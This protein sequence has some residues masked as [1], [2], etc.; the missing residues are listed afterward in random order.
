MSN[1]MIE[2][3][4]G[5]N[6][7][8]LA[9]NGQNIYV[10][11]G[12]DAD[13]I[14]GYDDKKSK[15]TGSYFNIDAGNGNNVVT[16]GSSWNHAS[17]QCGKDA[18]FVINKANNSNIVAGASNDVI[19][20]EGNYT[21]I[22]GGA[23]G[24]IITNYGSHVYISGDT[25][26]DSVRPSSDY[27]YTSK[28]TDVTIDGGKNDDIIEAWHDVRAS[29]SGG[30]GND[31]IYLYRVTTEDK[32][33]II[34]KGITTTAGQIFSK[35]NKTTEA[36]SNFWGNLN[37]ANEIYS[38]LKAKDIGRVIQT[39]VIAGIDAISPVPIGDFLEIKSY[40]DEL[41]LSS[42]TVI[43][44]KGDDTIVS[45]GFAPRIF[46]YAEGDGNDVLHRFNVTKKNKDASKMSTLYITKGL[47]SEVEIIGSDVI[48]KIGKGSV[49]LVNGANH[50]FKLR[51][52]DGTLTTRSYRK[53]SKGEVVCSIFG[54][55]KSET[56][57]DNVGIKRQTY[58][59][60]PG[61]IHK[62]K[63][64]GTINKSVMYGYGGKDV[65]IANDKDTTL[66]GGNGKDYL[67]GGD[68]ND[69]LYGGDGNDTLYGGNGNDILYGGDDNNKLYGNE[70]N[71]TLY[72]G[73]G[74]GYLSGGDGNDSIIGGLGHE[75]LI[76]GIDDDTLIGNGGA[77]TFVYANG[78][79]KDTITDYTAGE[80]K[81]KITSG[82]ISK[83]TVSGKD[84]IF[85]VGN[86]S[87]TVKN[88]KGKKITVVNSKGKTST[89]TYTKNSS[90]NT[91]ELWF[92][93]DNT[94]F[95]TS[96][97]QID[98]ITQNGLADYSLGNVNTTTD[99]TALTPTD[100]L[101]SALTFSD[102]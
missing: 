76:G 14:Y 94:N 43:G 85:S 92:T 9:G 29:I 15:H 58:I 73:T 40:L 71:D 74:I 2:V 6:L 19:T 5:E 88:G 56:L 77:D 90:A 54:S 27:I 75:S 4:D 44:G 7:V 102:K 38:G 17:I 63:I 59:S 87:I 84:V 78:D 53:D 18:D 23:D 69:I 55:S 50:K 25:S 60:N 1:A 30:K 46:K 45:D 13:F 82:S 24:D 96:S 100:A 86:G 16:I 89:K 37:T 3:G 83:T 35:I 10:K 21:S 8:S 70:G 28:G 68:G 39:G 101:T 64:I 66:D 93:S 95:S 80:D 36:I 61:T 62:D 72:G 52:A 22:F 26:V 20:N 32:K 81:I 41:T 48:L 51:E 65:L 98:S 91:A 31:L 49:R 79:G 34:W 57:M 42:T 67:I 97:A 12:N 33:H 47:I 11:G 99:W